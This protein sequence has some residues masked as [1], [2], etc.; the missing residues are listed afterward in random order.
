MELKNA[1]QYLYQEVISKSTYDELIGKKIIHPTD[2]L[3]LNLSQKMFRLLEMMCKQYDIVLEKLPDPISSDDT[4]KLLSIY[5]ELKRSLE[6]KKFE[7][8]RKSQ[9]EI[10]K[11]NQKI[12]QI[13]DIIFKGNLEMVYRLL[14]KYA[15]NIENPQDK[16]DIYQYGYEILL[17]A[18]DKYRTRC[19]K[20]FLE[21]VSGLIHKTI[22]PN[23]NL[24]NSII[25][26]SLDRISEQ[27]ELTE[28]QS[29]EYSLNSNCYGQEKHL[30]DIITSKEIKKVVMTLPDL[31]QKALI[32][33]FGLDGR[34]IRNTTDASHELGISRESLIF[35][36]KRALISLSL[37]PRRDYLKAIYFE[38]DFF[39][40]RN[41]Y[42]E[43]EGLNFDIDIDTLE[44]NRKNTED[45]LIR[46]MP[47][48]EFADLIS[49]FSE[50]IKEILSLSYGLV[51]GV[52]YNNKEIAKRLGVSES[53]VYLKKNNGIFLLREILK[54]KYRRKYYRYYDKD[55]LDFMM[56]EYLT[57]HK[58]PCK[59]K[60]KTK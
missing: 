41:V 45:F 36:R 17:Y 26:D 51:D 40:P 19:K 58:S 30:I 2:Y 49:S 53:T 50:E 24:L 3:F 15:N 1:K 56:Y 31:E 44:R 21:Y 6:N 12:T 20:S 27:E 48:S 4:L 23:S 47:K 57:G 55:Y 11:I 42:Q 9:V 16:E 14:T 34:G 5:H 52:L 8:S 7:E 43:I 29:S 38:T 54:E 33:S 18:I 22:F 59:S 28:E 46:N 35:N 13:R 10:E 39:Y 37:P 32:V 60:R 25:V